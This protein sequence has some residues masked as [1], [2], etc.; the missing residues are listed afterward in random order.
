VCASTV[1]MQVVCGVAHAVHERIAQFAALPKQDGLTAVSDATFGKFLLA[2]DRPYHTFLLF[3][4][5]GGYHSCDACRWVWRKLLRAV[6]L[7]PSPCMVGEGLLAP[8]AV[9]CDAAVCLP[10]GAALT[11]SRTGRA[12]AV[13]VCV[14]LS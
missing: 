14:S 9:R 5:S 6:G 11:P 1:C 8:P 4:S 13:C 12:A 10:A 7:R 3:T 2:K